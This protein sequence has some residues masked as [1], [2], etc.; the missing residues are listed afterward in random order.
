[1]AISKERKQA[2]VTQYKELLS[3]NSALIMTAY[4]GLS[5]KE[6]QG[7]R[8]KIRD[9]GGSFHI[10]KNNLVERAFNEV[11]VP[12]PEG[13]L[14]GP[15]A[16]GFSSEDILA[17]AKAIVDLAREV[18]FVQVKG[19][20]IDGVIYDDSQVMQLADLPPLPVVQ[21]Q[22]LRVIQTPARQLAGVLSGSARQLV[23][24][25]K[26][27]SETEAAPAQV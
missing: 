11:G 26:A 4:S 14:M 12:F 5:V 17:V 24:V 15:T 20:V 10:V 16:I 22:L 23:N 18:E 8:S 19:A 13:S 3:S 25:L 1:M 7:L 27:Y 2:L 21:A 9:A 6:I